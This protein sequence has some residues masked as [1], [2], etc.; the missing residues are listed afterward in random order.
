MLGTGEAAVWLRQAVAALAEL[1]VLL[2]LLLRRDP[3]E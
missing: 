3:N 2:L 1:L